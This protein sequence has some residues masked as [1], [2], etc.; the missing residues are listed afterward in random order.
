VSDRRRD[1]VHRAA[2]G[3]AGREAQRPFG[4]AQDPIGR[5]GQLRSVQVA[6]EIVYR[7]AQFLDRV[8]DALYGVVDPCSELGR[9]RR[10]GSLQPEADCVQPLNDEIVQVGGDPLALVEQRD[11]F[12]APRERGLGRHPRGD[13][14]CQHEESLDRTVDQVRRVG[15]LCVP[16]GPVRIAH[17][18]VECLRLASEDQGDVRAVLLVELVP[19]DVSHVHPPHIAR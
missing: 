15:H 7:R 6:L 19:Q 8:V 9:C 13:V 3:D 5:G 11:F 4:L 18:A 14:G 16:D 2:V 17:H 1:A 10:A 12:D